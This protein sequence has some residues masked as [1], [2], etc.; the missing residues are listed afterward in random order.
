M[1]QCTQTPRKGTTRKS[2]KRHRA[3]RISRLHDM[4]EIVRMHACIEPQESQDSTMYCQ[5][6]QNCSTQMPQATRQTTQNCTTQMPQ[7]Q[8]FT[9]PQELA[10][11]RQSMQVNTQASQDAHHL[12]Q[13]ASPQHHLPTKEAKPRHPPAHTVLASVVSATDI[14]VAVLIVEPLGSIIC[15]GST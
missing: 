8:S 7:A 2:H 10:Q 13:R 15:G 1:V 6:T 9:T 11:Y 5:E 3:T 4:L 12:V 14:T